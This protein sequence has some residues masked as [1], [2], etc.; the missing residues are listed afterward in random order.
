MGRGSS[1]AFLRVVPGVWIYL[2]T[3]GCKRLQTG[4]DCI[5]SLLRILVLFE[6]RSPQAGL[7]PHAGGK[8]GSGRLSGHP[9][10]ASKTSPD[11][12]RSSDP[13]NQGVKFTSLTVWRHR[14]IR[15]NLTNR[16]LLIP[17]ACS[18]RDRPAMDAPARPS[19]SLMGSICPEA[20]RLFTELTNSLKRV[21]EIQSCQIAAVQLGDRRVS[22]FDEEIRIALRAWR[23]SRRAYVQHV[24]DHGCSSGKD[25]I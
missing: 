13:Q 11:Q 21:V 10:S 9:N 20:E 2:R 4:Y 18:S 7:L 25:L 14:L 6:D 3:A 23:L 12:C 5:A 22:G 16:C 17:D 1:A 8:G 19:R 24:L 15:R